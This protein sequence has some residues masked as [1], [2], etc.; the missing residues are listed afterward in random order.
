MRN[1]WSHRLAQL[2]V[3]R[4]Q[5][6]E[7]VARL[8]SEALELAWSAVKAAFVIGVASGAVIAALM[9]GILLWLTK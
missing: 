2:A 5:A 6:S 3:S 8:S 4:D 1:P 7:I 9:G